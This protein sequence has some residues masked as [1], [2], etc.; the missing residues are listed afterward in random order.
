MHQGERFE[1]VINSD[2]SAII[3]WQAKE[4]VK[5]IEFKTG[6]QVVVCITVR[7]VSKCEVS[8]GEQCT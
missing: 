7:S 3:K 1:G 2:S 5:L 6:R 4:R 8:I